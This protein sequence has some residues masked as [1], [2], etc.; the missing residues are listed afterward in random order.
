[1]NKTEFLRLWGREAVNQPGV[2]V[3]TVVLTKEPIL[4]RPVMRKSA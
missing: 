1:M 3:E 4:M 2:P